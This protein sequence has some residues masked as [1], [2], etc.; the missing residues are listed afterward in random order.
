MTLHRPL[1]RFLDTAVVVAPIP[2]GL[3]AAEA[4][5]PHATPS[6]TGPVHPVLSFD[7]LGAQVAAL[8]KRKIQV[9]AYYLTSRN[10]E[11][12]DRHPEWLVVRVAPRSSRRTSL[13]AAAP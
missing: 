12:A 2:V 5:P 9:V 13:T 11:L 4:R 10:S 1:R 6:K 8:R 3:F 7:L